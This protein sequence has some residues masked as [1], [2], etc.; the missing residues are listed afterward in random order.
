MKLYYSTGSCS[1]SCVIGAFEAGVQCELIEVSWKDNKNVSELERLNPLGVAPVLILDDGQVLTQNAAILE[2]FSD[3]AQSRAFL[4]A[5]G[6]PERAQAMSWLSFVASDFH[7]SFVPLFVL[8]DMVKDPSAR[9]QVAEFAR[10]K[11]GEYLAHIERSLQGKKFLTG[12][13]FTVGDA[14]LFVTLHWCQWVDVSLSR[15]PSIEGYLKRLAE[16][17]SVKKAVA[18]EGN[19]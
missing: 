1:M 12:E 13:N 19:E 2:Y 8:E 18:L 14:Y 7:K 5:P 3:R 6:T 4:P 11:I 15:Y 10:G 16:R 17:P 9:G